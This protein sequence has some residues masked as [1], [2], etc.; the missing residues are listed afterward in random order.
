M[1]RKFH[2]VKI[3]KKS[4]VVLWGMGKPINIGTGKD[5]TIRELAEIVH[6]VVGFSGG[7]D[8][9]DGVGGRGCVDV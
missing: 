6:S 2:E 1:I 7:M 3:A 5:L 9:E 8:G 4:E